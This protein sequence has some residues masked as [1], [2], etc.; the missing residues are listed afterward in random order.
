MGCDV[1]Y[2]ATGRGQPFAVVAKRLLR[3]Q[4]AKPT[5]NQ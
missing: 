4:Y 1:A 3:I 5:G 2:A